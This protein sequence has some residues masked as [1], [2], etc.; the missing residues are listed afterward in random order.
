MKFYKTTIKITVYIICIFLIYNIICKIA[1]SL[2]GIKEFSLISF[3][4]SISIY[5]GI[6]AMQLF[7][8]KIHENI[9]ERV[10]VLCSSTAIKVLKSS[11]IIS[12]K[13]F[14]INISFVFVF[15]ILTYSS[16]KIGME[17]IIAGILLLGC[18]EVVIIMI[19]E[20]FLFWAN[21]IIDY[22]ISKKQM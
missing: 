12:A 19:V 6:F 2:K 17:K 21:E 16:I 4:S 11:S 1:L 10:S 18:Y 13:I 8:R 3:I 22:I 5:C 7:F 15:M 9:V 20:Y 14:L